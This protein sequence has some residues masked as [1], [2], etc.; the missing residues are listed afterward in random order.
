MK[1]TDVGE[2][3]WAPKWNAC[4]NCGGTRRDHMARGYCRVCYGLVRRRDTINR[5]DPADPVT[6][7]GFPRG[8]E[9]T[10]QLANRFG[11]IKAE[12]T[13]QVELHLERLRY[14]ERK[15]SSRID[16]IDIEHQ[17]ERFDR[18]LKTRRSNQNH[19]YHGIADDINYKFELEQRLVLYKILNKIEDNW[20]TSAINWNKCGINAY[21]ELCAEINVVDIFVRV[22]N[23]L[24]V[25]SAS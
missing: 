3:K 7:R 20:L 15:L 22:S 24:Y 10:L 4:L 8:I 17:L 9:L 18:H 23:V 12:C 21:D 2:P 6:L 25:S 14:M 5:W 13:N 16:G 19:P 1:A 11:C